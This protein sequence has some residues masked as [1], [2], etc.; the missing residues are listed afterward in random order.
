MVKRK[1]IRVSWN[2]VDVLSAAKDAVTGHRARSVL[3]SY[4][5]NSETVRS[6]GCTLTIVGGN[7]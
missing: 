6:G 3:S 5:F 1:G 7:K 2:K 4:R